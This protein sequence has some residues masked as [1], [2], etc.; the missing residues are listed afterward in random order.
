[1]PGPT[2]LHRPSEPSH[3]S[4]A[5]RKQAKRHSELRSQLTS[6]EEVLGEHDQLG[7]L[8]RG[9]ADE[10]VGLGEVLGVRV[11]RVVGRERI[12]LDECDLEVAGHG[13]RGWACGERAERGE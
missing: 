2:R 4:P 1:V 13:C 6:A 3:V 5:T 7:A 12:E 10:G 8:S 11:M 9:V